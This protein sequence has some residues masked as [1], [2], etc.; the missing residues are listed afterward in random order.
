MHPEWRP[1]GDRVATEWRP[2]GDR[3]AGHKNGF[4]NLWFG[5]EIT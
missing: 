3:V 4:A 5:N 2:S 1:S